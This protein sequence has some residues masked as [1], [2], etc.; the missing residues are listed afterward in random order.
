MDR[1]ERLRQAKEKLKK[2]Q[3]KRQGG[4]STTQSTPDLDDISNKGSSKRSTPKNDALEE[5]PNSLEP[6]LFTFDTKTENCDPFVPNTD[7]SDGRSSVSDQIQCILEGSNICNVADNEV[8]IL[9]ARLGQLEKE[10]NDFQNSIQQQEQQIRQLQKNIDDSVSIAW[11]VSV[12]SSTMYRVWHSNLDCPRNMLLIKKS[13]IFTQS[14]RKLAKLMYT[15][16][17]YVGQI[18][19]N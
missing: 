3:K 2:F 14:L 16:A 19:S 13:T 11:L 1:E 8:D 4:E 6:T 18:S 12:C 7:V 10:N 17:G 15:W 5:E 9:K